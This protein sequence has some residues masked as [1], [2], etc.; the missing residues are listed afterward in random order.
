MENLPIIQDFVPYR[1]RCPKRM[2]SKRNDCE[3]RLGEERESK[4]REEGIE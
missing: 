1:G 2:A 4:E 3:R